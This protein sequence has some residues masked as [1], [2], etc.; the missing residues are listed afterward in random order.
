M[1]GVADEKDLVALFGVADCLHV[2]LGDEGAGGVDKC[3]FT[4]FCGVSYFGA[5]AVCAEDDG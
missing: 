2:D 3:A 4:C 1:T 5:D